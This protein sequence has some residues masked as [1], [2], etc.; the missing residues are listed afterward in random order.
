MYVRFHTK[1]VNLLDT[2]SV[3]RKTELFSGLSDAE[4]EFLI[5]EMD[6]RILNYKKGEIIYLDSDKAD[7]IFI[8]LKGSVI[9]E[10]NNVCG[11][12]CLIS[13]FSVGK[14]FGLPYAVMPNAIRTL[15]AIA[16]QDCTIISLDIN[17]ILA[18]NKKI[19]AHPI[20]LRNLLIA[21]AS[22]LASEVEH[23]RKNRTTRVKLLS[24][25][26]LQARKHGSR[27]FDIAFTRQELADY[28]GVQRAAMCTEL[29][30]LK[31]EGIINFNRRRFEIYADDPFNLENI[32]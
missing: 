29:A 18:D 10:R 16:N 13:D 5:A 21:I 15:N 30:R 22:K 2:L 14:L 7:G 17:K 11:T 28:L 31:K 27:S 32:E 9:L 6:S 8:V 23:P 25:L 24:F 3:L 12:C 4:I 26:F 19:A 20:L 1:E